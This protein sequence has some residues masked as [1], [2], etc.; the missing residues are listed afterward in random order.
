MWGKEQ[1]ELLS[2]VYRI[3]AW[4]DESILE[5]DSCSGCATVQIS[6]MPLNCTHKM[7][8]FMLCILS[9]NKCLIVLNDV[10]SKLSPCFLFSL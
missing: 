6:S 1:W 3:P 10:Y 4:D 5:L 2:N 7:V 9:K 8:D